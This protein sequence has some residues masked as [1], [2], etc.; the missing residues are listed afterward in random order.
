MKLSHSVI[1]LTSLKGSS[2]DLCGHNIEKRDAVAKVNDVFGVV[3]QF[4]D[5]LTN[6]MDKGDKGGKGNFL[7]C[8]CL[9]ET[10]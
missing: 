4:M 3:Q 5:V 10:F 7:L 1:D 2:A 8:C 9:N 6:A